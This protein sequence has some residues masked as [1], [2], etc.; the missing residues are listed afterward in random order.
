M[1]MDFITVSTEEIGYAS[2]LKKLIM[3][4]SVDG[5]DNIII[6]VK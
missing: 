4:L 1:E 5:I 2:I 3:L 6:S